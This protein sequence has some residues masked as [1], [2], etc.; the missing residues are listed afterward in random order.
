M[1]AFLGGQLS[2]IPHGRDQSFSVDSVLRP[3]M[4]RTD[5]RSGVEASRRCGP[6]RLFNLDTAD[7]YG[8]IS[9]QSDEGDSVASRAP[10]VQ[11]GTS[12][13]ASVPRRRDVNCPPELP[14]ESAQKRSVGDWTG[15]PVIAPRVGMLQAL[16]GDRRS[17]RWAAAPA[18]AGVAPKRGARAFQAGWN[19]GRLPS[20]HVETR[21]FFVVTVGAG[22]ASC[23]FFGRERHGDAAF[24]VP[25]RD[26]SDDGSGRCEG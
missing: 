9:P 26:V 5:P 17:G 1:A 14:A 15:A 8:M 16:R 2:L 10:P 24:P 7:V 23:R 3:R 25:R 13:A 12:S 18:A 22:E 21:S 19:R 4:A 6:R 11:R 20:L